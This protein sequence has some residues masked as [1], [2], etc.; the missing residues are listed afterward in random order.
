[1]DNILKLVVGCLGAV[2][3]LVMLIPNGDP[4]TK[5]PG[6]SVDTAPAAAPSPADAPPVA[7]PTSVPESGGSFTVQD[8]DIASFGKPMVDPTPPGQA[9]E[10]Q[11]QPS[12]NEGSSSSAPAQNIV[13][14]PGYGAPPQIPAKPAPVPQAQ[15]GTSDD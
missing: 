14:G 7:P 9:S 1:M 15:Q 8:H 3:V 2:A 5:K 10:Q 6:A 4:L 12:S 13:P 11:I